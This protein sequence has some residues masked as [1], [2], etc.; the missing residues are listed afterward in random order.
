MHRIGRE[1]A[2][3]TTVRAVAWLGALLLS[4]NAIASSELPHGAKCRQEIR[5]VDD[6]ADVDIQAIGRLITLLEEEVDDRA[7]ASGGQ[8]DRLRERLDAAKLQRTG[9]LDKQHDDL[10]MIRARCDRLREDAKRTA[11]PDNAALSER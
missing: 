2:I 11:A 5:A 9:L 6:Q 3:N 7:I 1:T 8:L 10:N 4:G